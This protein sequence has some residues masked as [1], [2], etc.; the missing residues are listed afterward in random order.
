MCR[1]S[2]RS[3]CHDGFWA[4]GPPSTDIPKALLYNFV[5]VNSG[6]AG[7]GGFA[8]VPLG[9]VTSLMLAKPA[10]PPRIRDVILTTSPHN[11]VPHEHG[12]RTQPST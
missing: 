3:I 4:Y 7:R 12:F 11:P 6:E 9:R 8:A 2:N 1:I 10:E 5:R